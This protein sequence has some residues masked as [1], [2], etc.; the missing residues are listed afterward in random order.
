MIPQW[1]DGDPV[2]LEAAAHDAMVWLVLVRER[3]ATSGLVRG[4]KAEL[5]GCIAALERLT[6]PTTPPEAPGHGE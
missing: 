4:N 3:F 6:P 5:D 2:N 1:K